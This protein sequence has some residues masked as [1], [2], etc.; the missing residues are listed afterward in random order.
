MR[1]KVVFFSLFLASLVPAHAD[2]YTNMT[3]TGSSLVSWGGEY[4]SPYWATTNGVDRFLISCLDVTVNTYVGQSYSYHTTTNTVPGSNDTTPLYQYQAAAILAEQILG[5]TGDL[6]GELS[7]AIWDIF[8]PTYV[9]AWSNSQVHN[10]LA[11]IQHYADLAKAQAQGGGYVPNFTLYYP[12]S[13]GNP[14]VPGTP[15]S[16]MYIRIVPDGGLTLM[17]LGGALV[18]LEAL[19]RRFRA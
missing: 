12:D 9:A 11:T 3:L 17:L 14:P 19:R 6:R 8:N 4:V 15:G 7:W 2:V 10:N 1:M 18:G 13:D 16:Q 5:A